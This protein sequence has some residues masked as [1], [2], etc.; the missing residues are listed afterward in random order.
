MSTP[1]D[2]R[3]DA[4]EQERYEREGPAPDQPCDVEW[5]GWSDEDEPIEGG[6]FVHEI[7]RDGADV[8]V[9]CKCEHHGA[10]IQMR[11]YRASY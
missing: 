11:V 5:C 1:D 7:E 9:Y 3:A 10:D 6:F 4:R 2:L 8:M